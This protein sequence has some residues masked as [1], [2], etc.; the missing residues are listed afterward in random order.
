MQLK[1][2]QNGE[3]QHLN[4]KIQIHMRGYKV[5][6]MRNKDAIKR[7]SHN[8]KIKLSNGKI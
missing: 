3:I 8:C 5:A 6:I 4:R 2:S 7:K 1:E